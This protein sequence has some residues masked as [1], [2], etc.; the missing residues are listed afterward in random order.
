MSDVEKVIKKA[1]SKN[2]RESF[3]QLLSVE[4]TSHL[5]L[6]RKLNIP[7]ISKELFINQAVENYADFSEYFNKLDNLDKPEEQ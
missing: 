2:S 5:L 3:I 4:Y 1:L 7:P 6:C